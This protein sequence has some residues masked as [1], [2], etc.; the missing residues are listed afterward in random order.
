M[1]GLIGLT[2]ADIDLQDILKA[3]R[4]EYDGEWIPHPV[5][6]LTTTLPVA[7]Q[8]PDVRTIVRARWGFDVG[9]GRPIGNA[10]DDKLLESRLWGSMFG[11]SHCLVASTGIYEMIEVEGKKES[12]WFRRRDKKPIVMPGI[13]G[14]RHAKGEDRLCAAMITTEPNDFFGEYHD[15]QVC[16]LSSREMD[17]WL[18]N[19]EPKGFM[20][21]LHAPEND[22][23]EAVP[24]DGRIFRPGRVEMEHLVEQGKPLRWSGK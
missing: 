20:K 16:T 6:R 22:E 5:V 19:G 23:W 13:C 17:A 9:A 21:L 2:A 7:V 14:M 12:Y 4:W 15:R 3:P 8:K 1:A 10:R 11:K 24:V 18:S